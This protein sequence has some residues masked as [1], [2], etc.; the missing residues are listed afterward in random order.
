M[1]ENTQIRMDIQKKNQNLVYSAE[2]RKSKPDT[3][4][5]SVKPAFPFSPKVRIFIQGGIVYHIN[6]YFNHRKERSL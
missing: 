3:V 1:H 2:N 4:E 5:Q 6:R